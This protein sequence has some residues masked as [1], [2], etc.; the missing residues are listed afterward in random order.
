MHRICLLLLIVF[1]AEIRADSWSPFEDYRAVSPHRTAYL[2]ARKADKGGLAFELARS[3]TVVARGTLSW[4]PSE[5]QALEDGRGAVL[6]ETYAHGYGHGL[7]FARMDGRGRILWKLDVK[8]LKLDGEW[9]RYDR[10]DASVLYVSFWWVEKGRIGLLTT[11]G[12]VRFIDLES[13][14]VSVIADGM[15]V[16]RKWASSV[17]ADRG[18]DPFRRI[19][20]YHLSRPEADVRVWKSA[21]SDPF[22][23]QKDLGKDSDAVVRWALAIPELRPFELSICSAMGAAGVA[24]VLDAMAK[25]GGAWS[26]MPSQFERHFPQRLCDG[27]AVRFAGMDAA[28]RLRAI[29]LIAASLDA[30][31]RRTRNRSRSF[32]IRNR[33]RLRGSRSS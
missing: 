2:I 10:S 16:V 7:A 5:I 17:A 21:R 30:R 32:W 20:A 11:L 19:A 14:K 22:Q 8:D 13:G 12:T 28:A 23:L 29:G 15:P 27:L 9:K 24:P 6:F 31:W 26:S 1:C 4:R 18:V 3:G 25:S 33:R